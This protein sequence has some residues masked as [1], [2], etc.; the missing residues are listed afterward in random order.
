MPQQRQITDAQIQAICGHQ[1]STL[2]LYANERELKQQIADL[3][4][5]ECLDC[6]RKKQ[7][8]TDDSLSGKKRKKAG[9]GK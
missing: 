7:A 2:I 4:R 3:A 6:I 8:L 9:K 1:Y 5:Y